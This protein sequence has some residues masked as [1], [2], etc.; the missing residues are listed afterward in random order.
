VTQ[1]FQDEEGIQE[2][3]KG[4]SVMAKKA[5][6]SK[7]KRV[8]KSGGNKMD[9]N[10]VPLDYAVIEFPGNQFKGEIAPEIY[11]LV[12]EGLI[13]IIDL[14][15][16]SK[17][18][19]GNFTLL[20]LNDLTDEQYSQFAPLTE[21]LAPLFTAEDV[22]SLAASVP[23]NSSALAVLWQ[24]VW[25]EKFRRAVANANGKVRVHERVPADVLN[26]VMA[27]VA[28]AKK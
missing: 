25:T 19:Q 10:I 23:A 2:Q 28:A 15:F 9:E 4:E 12:E 11:R 7:K 20:E 16:I 18:K 27:E 3:E 14:V 8:P 21:H 1:S 6:P 26:E 5:S 13:R 22:A 17:D 24:N